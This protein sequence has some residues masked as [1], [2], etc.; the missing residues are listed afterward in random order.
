[1]T[2]RYADTRQKSMIATLLMSPTTS[3]FISFRRKQIVGVFYACRLQI[4]IICT[5]LLLYT[6]CTLQLNVR[7]VQ[8]EYQLES[9][10]RDVTRPLKEVESKSCIVCVPRSTPCFQ[11]FKAGNDELQTNAGMCIDARTLTTLLTSKVRIS[12]TDVCDRMQ[13]INATCARELA[14]GC[15]QQELETISRLRLTHTLVNRRCRTSGKSRRIDV[16]K[17]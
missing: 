2:V 8:L 15:I 11:V 16:V 1:M 13:T 10:Q 14:L 12:Q 17:Y 5:A 7:S 3:S 4:T 6:S 9:Q